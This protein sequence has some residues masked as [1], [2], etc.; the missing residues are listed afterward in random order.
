MY[1]DKWKF[2]IGYVIMLGSRSTAYKSKKQEYMA[3][4]SIESKYMVLS[5]GATKE[6]WLLKL[7]WDLR[8]KQKEPTM[9]MCDNISAIKMAKNDMFY[10]KI[11][12]IKQYYYFMH[13]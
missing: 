7:L 11:K 6:A 8:A 4:L 5:N 13:E 10:N 12:H 1:L 2:N 9:I 3:R